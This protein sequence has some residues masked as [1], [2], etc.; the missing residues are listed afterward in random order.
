MERNRDRDRVSMRE[1]GERERRIYSSYSDRGLSVFGFG[2]SC[3]GSEK[4]VETG[5][6]DSSPSHT[7][8]LSLYLFLSS[9][10]VSVSL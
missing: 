4:T 6:V 1:S 7:D 9:L 2:V 8:T 3:L 10:G 5:S